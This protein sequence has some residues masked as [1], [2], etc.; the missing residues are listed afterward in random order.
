MAK[1]YYS[2]AYSKKF[3]QGRKTPYMVAVILY[4]VCRIQKTRHLLIDFSSIIQANLFILGSIYLKFIKIFNLI[5]PVIDPSL[6]IQRFCSKLN[7]GDK[8][9]SV[10]NTALKL[11]QLMDRDWL[12]TGRRPSG[13]CGACILISARMHEFNRS[14]DQITNV[15]HVCN[16][17]VRKRLKEFSK[18]SAALL[19]KEKFDEINIELYLGKEPPAFLKNRDKEKSL[20]SDETNDTVNKIKSI[21][22]IFNQSNKKDKT[23]FSDKQRNNLNETNEILKPQENL[24]ANEIFLIPRSINKNESMDL[25]FVRP[26][27]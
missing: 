24:L 2:L 4:T 26:C 20:A 23:A 1:R 16:E 12:V 14:V 22:K 15:V 8:T 25:N 5:I 9:K 7:F 21:E 13:L 3:T 10:S 18:T 17:T 6:F 19:T 27:K 11:L